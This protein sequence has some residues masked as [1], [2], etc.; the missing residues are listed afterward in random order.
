MAALTESIRKPTTFLLAV[1]LW[2]HAVLFL[3][4]HSAVISKCSQLLHLTTSEAALFILLLTF[5]LVTCSGFWRSL[6]SLAY[7]YGFPIVL[8]GYALYGC[9][10]A[11]RGVN[12]WFVSQADPG[13]KE[14][15]L[16]VQKEAEASSSCVVAHP[17][18]G[19]Q[20]GAKEKSLDVLCVLLRPFRTA[21][22]LWCLLLLFTT[23]TWVLWLSLIVVLL[24]LMGK[25]FR[26]LKATL[27]AAPFLRKAGLQLLRRVDTALQGLDLVTTES[28]PTPELKNLF[29]QL[30]TIDKVTRFLGNRDLVVRWALLLAA[31]FLGGVYIYIAILFSFV[32]YAI[33]RV[34]AVAYSWPEALVTSLFVPFLIGDLPRVVMAKLL[35]GIQCT[36]IVTV[37][38]GTVLT[39]IRRRLDRIQV[40]A[41][42]I[43]KRFADQSVRERYLILQEKAGTTIANIPSR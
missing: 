28:T 35:G 18:R 43:G 29:N 12:R 8:L 1:F 40:E 39:Y 27:F 14:I 13:L 42:A 30:S 26:L 2:L 32:Y 38:V 20:V 34:S 25:V 41:M 15:D 21:T 5:S 10:L 16:A 31:V 11:L 37:G 9:F 4:V 24:Q 19:N 33:A 17:Q 3:N 7:V 23:H 6:R 22:F 36:L